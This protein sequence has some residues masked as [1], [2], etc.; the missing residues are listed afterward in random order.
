MRLLQERWKKPMKNY[1]IISHTHWD[2]EWYLPFE[3]FRIRLVDMMDN[4]LDILRCDPEYRFH[5]DAQTIVLEDYLEIKPHR[6][7][8]LEKY[9]GEGRLLIGPWY[10]QNDFHLTSG[11][12]TVR[13]LIIGSD[14]A[15]KF[16]GCMQ[17]GYAADQFGLCSQLPQILRRFGLDT[18]VFGRGY[19]RGES[20]FYW[21]A[22]DG[23]EVLCEHMKDW[24]NNLQR[25]PDNPEG[26]YNLLIS[27][28]KLCAQRGKTDSY[29]LMNGVD[30][31]EAQDNLTEIIGM[32]RPMMG[33]D[34]RVFQDTLPEYMD[35]LKAELQ[36]KGTDMKCYQGEF[37]DLGAGSVLTGTL[38]SRVYLK[39]MN[40][41][42][43][44]DIEGRFEPGYSLLDIL[45]I[46]K[47]PIGYSRYLWK[48]LIQNHPHDS[49]C[50]C[51]VDPVH[52]HMTD[53]FE[54]I[55]E[56]L[57]ELDARA[58]EELIK[59]IDRTATAKDDI[60]IVCANNSMYPYN[61]IIEAE[62]DID[63]GTDLGG[64][65][66]TDEKGKEVPFE[67]A[68]V[69][70]NIGKRVLSPINLPGERRV[71]RYSLLLRPGKID[72]MTRKTLLLSPIAE[73]MDVTPSRN[74]GLR[75]M[76]NECIKVRIN[77]NGSV[78][79]TD[80]SS[81]VAYKNSLIFEDDMDL[82]DS[83]NFCKYNGPEGSGL[84]TSENTKA[85]VFK[86]SDTPMRS[87][88][89]VSFTLNIDRITG[90]GEIPVELLL[91]LDAGSRFVSV[92][93]KI[94]NRLKYHRLRVRIPTG[95]ISDTNY[96][97]QPFDTV[98]RNKI[99]LYKND[100]THPCTGFVGIDGPG[101]GISVLSE[102]LYEY[103]HMAGENDGTLALTLLRA[104]GRVTGGFGETDEKNVTE[105][106][107]APE[108]QCIGDYTLRFAVYPY[109][110]DHISAGT[111]VMAGQFLSPVYAVARYCDNNK[112]TGG[113]PFVQA[114]GVPE[115]YYRPLEN[116]DIVV[117]RRYS[118]FSIEQSMPNAMMLSAIKGAEDGAGQI[119]RLYN[120]TSESVGFSLKFTAKI[121]KASR[122]T[123]G[124][125][126]ISDIKVERGHRLVLSA[127]PKEIVTLRVTV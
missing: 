118:I 13:N 42:A 85:K 93:A 101:Y 75:I 69:K 113:R 127:K 55:F 121:K 62:V 49:I 102:G 14:I 65:R 84:V 111:A 79:I 20:Q 83:Y 103:E 46:K 10:V 106:W 7:S 19:G 35:R 105:G 120:T 5:L 81:G 15:K 58:D 109:T 71:N 68:S 22:E 115:L 126:F 45:G 74:K 29:L 28:G 24:Y 12:A 6:R 107:E 38:S 54:R 26:A 57:A 66:I 60:F 86:V 78:D 100:E 94:S 70:R 1:C 87:V 64:F 36:E 27:R 119:I 96:A 63:T 47:Y 18:C 32:L 80:K 110:G 61:G 72:G 108:C 92:A 39:Q 9:V 37:R 48:T 30:H 33:E 117:P 25:L 67:I 98:I 16:G 91:T 73:P 17:I 89:R 21:R 56:N 51:S 82:G 41:R 124:E 50:G 125:E 76:E 43:Q 4:L 90:K 31:L 3:Q 122:A 88:R 114:A 34:E 97:G 59:H 99:S 104:A 77:E 8:E 2:R 40:A 116:A 112:M 44:A 95:I 53:R 23:S 52:R 123:L 11:E